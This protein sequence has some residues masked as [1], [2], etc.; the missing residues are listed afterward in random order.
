MM[1]RRPAGTGSLFARGDAGGRETWYATWYADGRKVKRRIGA[2]RVPGTRTGLTKTQ[3]E[4]ELR[5]LIGEVTAAVPREDRTALEEAGERYVEHLETVKRRKPTT[6]TD[7]RTILRRHLAPFMGDRAIDAVDGVLIRRYISAKLREGLSHKTVRNHVVFLHGLFGHAVARG[8]ARANPVD[9]ADLPVAGGTDPNIRYLRAEELEALY[10]ATPD[11]DLGRVERVLYMTAAMAGL[12]LG[13]LVGLPWSDINWTAGVIRVRRSF[14]H[15]AWSTPKSRT[16]SRAVPLPDRL[17]GELERHYQRSA[18]G[19]DDDLV[20]AHPQLGTVLDVSKLRKRFHAALERTEVRRV[21]FHDLRHSY[22]TAM[23][24]AGT[25]MRA[26]ME[27][28]GHASM[29]TTLI[30]ADYSPDPS[31]GVM[32]ANRA[33]AVR[34][35]TRGSNLSETQVTSEHLRAH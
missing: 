35:S 11:D 34:G 24:A 28:M 10:R 9:R 29:Q 16:S 23:A 13:E 4:A 25:P 2:K 1:S 27:F 17:A 31:G 33:F 22:G 6:I 32:H 18:F 20:F 19:H 21:R 12:R 5:R 14:T 3:A 7:Y 26:L 8:W 15:G 30:Y